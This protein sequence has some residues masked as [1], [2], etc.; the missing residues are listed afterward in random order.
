MR[1]AFP[2]ARLVAV[3]A[4]V[5][6]IRNGWEA[7]YKFWLP[8]YGNNL[9]AP[10][11]LLPEELQGS[12]LMLEGV[13]LQIVSGV[14][15]DAPNNTFVW[16][17]SIRTVVAGDIVFS[18]VHFGVPSGD[19]RAAWLA[20]LDRIAVLKPAVIVPGHQLA[21]AKNDL[22]AL[23][24][25]RKYMQDWDAAVASS[26]NAEELTARMKKLHPGLGMEQLLTN[27]SAAAFRR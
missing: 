3:P 4:V 20:T 10:P 24:F 7:R 2:S 17:P 25:M 22:S 18:G 6:G 11:P 14:Q 5:T 19:A 21:G 27:A 9:P 15:G 1:Q 13:E 26:R 23:E 16:I 12:A 8:T